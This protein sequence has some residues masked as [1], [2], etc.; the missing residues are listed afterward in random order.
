MSTPALNAYIRQITLFLGPHSSSKSAK[1][2]A[3]DE[4]ELSSNKA[5]ASTSKTRSVPP[6][7]SQ[8]TTQKP[9][10]RIVSRPQSRHP[11][12]PPTKLPTRT[13]SHTRTVSASGAKTASNVPKRIL[14]SS[15]NPTSH[16]QISKPAASSKSSA[17][18]SVSTD[19]DYEPEEEVVP[20]KR[21]RTYAK[22]S[23]AQSSPKRLVRSRKP[24]NAAKSSHDNANEGGSD[25][26]SDD[27]KQTADKESGTSTK[28]A[29]SSPKRLVR[30]RKP[31]SDASQ[32]SHRN[33][34]EDGSEDDEP[35]KMADEESEDE[36][37][38]VVSRRNPRVSMASSGRVAIVEIPL[39]RMSTDGVALSPASTHHP[40][41]P[42]ASVPEPRGKPQMCT[43][44][45]SSIVFF[46][47][48]IVVF[49][50]CAIQNSIHISSNSDRSPTTFICCTT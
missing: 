46:D 21:A 10:V 17:K 2:I 3:R 34:N 43:S 14:P 28:L 50:S 8:P 11:E 38:A 19:T 9:V 39:R 6:P 16:K 36:T 49:L 40:S 33:S 4:E 5:K 48:L 29:H 25:D 47:L 18:P 41:G 37:P 15:S 13:T 12:Q 45:A 27:P 24:P 23:T 26:D 1:R 42:M 22:R 35:K 30:G 31:P 32:P 7:K 44:P 20:P